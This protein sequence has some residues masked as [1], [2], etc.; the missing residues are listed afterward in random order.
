MKIENPWILGI[1]GVKT[2]GNENL[3]SYRDQ[4]V[5]RVRRAGINGP[6]GIKDEGKSCWIFVKLT[7]IWHRLPQGAADRIINPL[8]SIQNRKLVGP[9]YFLTQSPFHRQSFPHSV[10][11]WKQG[12]FPSL[13]WISRMSSCFERPTLV[14][15]PQYFAI[16]LIS[17]IFIFFDLLLMDS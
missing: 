2:A 16:F 3:V 8:P 1:S 7:V 4:D 10:L 15:I 5:G 12:S 11:V 17:C 9:F 6:A 14:S 13:T